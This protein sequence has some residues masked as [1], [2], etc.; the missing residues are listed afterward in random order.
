MTIFSIVPLARYSRVFP[1]A[2]RAGNSAD[3]VSSPRLHLSGRLHHGLFTQR[4]S[5]AIQRTSRFVHPSLELSKIPL[6]VLREVFG[7]AGVSEKRREH[8]AAILNG[9]RSPYAITRSARTRYSVTF[10]AT[11]FHGIWPQHA[12]LRRH[13]PLVGLV[14]VELTTSRLSGVRSNHLS[15]RPRC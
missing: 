12:W 6:A 13:A 4:T 10:T 9:G 3:H 15:Y 7:A 1:Y 2:T 11:V 14:R 5:G 8:T